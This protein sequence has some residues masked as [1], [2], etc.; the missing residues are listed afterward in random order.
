MTYTDG[1]IQDN[2]GTI[3]VDSAS[4]FSYSGYIKIEDEIIYYGERDTWGQDSFRQCLR[5]QLGT[6]ASDHPDNT[7]VYQYIIG[8]GDASWNPLYV[9]PISDNTRVYVDWDGDG[10]ADRPNGDVPVGTTYID[11][12]RF[13]IA[14]LW[15]TVEG[16]G[17]NGGAHI[18]AV[19]STDTVPPYR[20]KIITV[21]YG[22][23]AGAHSQQGYDW[24]FSLIPLHPAFVFDLVLD[25]AA[26]KSEAFSGDTI[27]YTFTVTNHGNTTIYDIAID[28]PMFG[29]IT[30]D[31]TDDVDADGRLDELADDASATASASYIVTS[32][33]DPGPI[34]NTA[35]AKGYQEDGQAGEADVISN[36]D[37]WT[38]DLLAPATINVTKNVVGPDGTEAADD[39]TGFTVTLDSSNEK[40]ISEGVTATYSNLG[41][42]TYTISENNIP[43]NYTFVG[44]SIDEDLN[45]AGAQITVTSGGV[46]DLVVTNKQKGS[47]HK[48]CQKCNSNPDGDDVADNHS[49]TVQRGGAD[50]KAIA[51]NAPNFYTVNPGTYIIT[52]VDDGN[53]TL[54][55][56]TGDNDSDASN[57]GNGYRRKR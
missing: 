1:Y 2:Y 18:W 41:P 15:D 12:N 38:V 57:G 4:D 39:T 46:V 13:E 51:E 30:W 48:H 20:E 5:G 44:Y 22:E 10:I 40:P 23:A 52:E 55:S 34:I 37:D 54:T 33:D 11:I 19:D 7:P 29:N 42:G 14:K 50:D 21:Y 3:D 47:Y 17:D 8:T 35:I 43:S 31:P 26:D 32:G 28:D 45:T 6:V 24:G 53:Y 36:I 56:I 49:F 27:Y 16:D 9:T 25:K